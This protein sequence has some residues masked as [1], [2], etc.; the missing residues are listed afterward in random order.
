LGRIARVGNQTNVTDDISNMAP[1][2]P[3]QSLTAP[4]PSRPTRR[5]RPVAILLV[6]VMLLAA[7]LVALRLTSGA[8]GAER[9]A[10]PLA[11]RETA[12]VHLDS[13]ADS[14]VVSTADL[15]GELALV[16][17]PGGDSS[18][19]R[20]RAE[21]DGDRLRVWTED[22]GDADDG[23]AVQIDVRI[24][25]DVRWDVVVDKG[26]KQVRLDL[27]AGQVN[28]VELRGGADL[29]D[30]T[31]PAPVG[32][33]TVRIPTGLATAALHAPA[34]VPAKVTFAKGAGRAV[35]DG[36]QR[37]G[38]AAGITIYGV[39]GKGGT[40]G[41]KGYSAAKNRLLIDVSA[42]VGTLSLDRTKP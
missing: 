8:D 31:L 15:A 6:V 30:V 7:V 25:R 10:I 12:I 11:G 32:E 5:A 42:G 22:I 29:A 18:G 27:G 40:G 41:A 19:V 28:A 26:A 20:P 4:P 21:M 39:N 35:V 2:H 3:T 9:V 36:A 23:A 16:T 33:Q 13:G 17:T 34:A 14:I 37:Q 24:A 38:I 1:T